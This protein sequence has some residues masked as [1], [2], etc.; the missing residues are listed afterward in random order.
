VTRADLACR[1]IDLGFDPVPIRD[2][3][4]L[5]KWRL[6]QFTHVT[7]A[8]ACDWWGVKWPDASMAVLCGMS[9]NLVVIDTDTR[10]AE[11]WAALH[12]PTT[13]RMVRTRR[14]WHRYYRHPGT[15]IKTK[16]FVVAPGV[17][18]DV[19]GD[20]G[21]CTAPGSVHPS[22]HVYRA[23]RLWLATDDVPVLPDCIVK[24][25]AEPSHFVEATE[26][27]VPTGDLATRF[28]QYLDKHPL[29]PAG[30]GSDRATFD[31]ACFALGIVGLDEQATI[32][33]IARRTGFDRKWVT[34]KVKS[35]AKKGRQ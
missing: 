32:E 9:H 17:A 34:Q 30:Q 18:L 20:G 8:L 21:Q 35:A 11:G 26:R 2:K 5:V 1:L 6:F 16:T 3:R 7:Y 10:E 15:K 14:G 27:R 12:L 24:I 19:K 22:G 31:A 29:P 4:P 23:T 13:T 25:A 28:G 33:E